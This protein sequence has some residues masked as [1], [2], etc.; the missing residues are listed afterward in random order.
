MRLDDIDTSDVD[1]EDQRGS[2]GGGGFGFPMGGGGGGLAL[3]GGMGGGRGVGRPPATGGSPDPVR[4]GTVAIT[5][6][7]GILSRNMIAAIAAG[8][9]AFYLLPQVIG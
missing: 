3:G 7:A 8:G 1:V 2:G 6:L 9:A 5:L 4:L